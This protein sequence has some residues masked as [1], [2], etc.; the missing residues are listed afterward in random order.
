MTTKALIPGE[1]IIAVDFD[2][3]ITTDPNMSKYEDMR[4]QPHCRNVLLRMFDSDIK[5]ILWTCRTGTALD[6]ALEFLGD[7]DMM[8]F[9]ATVNDQLP[10]VKEKYEPNVSRKIGAD[11]YIDDKV[12][13]VRIDWSE[14]EEFFYADEG[15]KA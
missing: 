3:T 8:P 5:L 14:I 13:M 15:A 4:L 12:P 11:F 6:E 2:G 10:E 1:L 9:F 7:N